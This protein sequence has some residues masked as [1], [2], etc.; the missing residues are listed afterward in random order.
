MTQSQV[1]NTTKTVLLVLFFTF[2]GEGVLGL[3]L[4]WPFLLLYINN[5]GIYW[6]ALVVGILVSFLNG[7]S[8]G[9]SSLVLVLGVV[10]LSFLGE[11]LR[12]KNGVLILVMVLLSWLVDRIIGVG[13]GVWESVILGLVAIPVLGWSRGGDSIHIKY[14]L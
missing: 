12:E 1:K 5:E 3:P 2:L 10:V 4:Y 11:F 7:I 6:L 9:L 13:H 14:R 8:L